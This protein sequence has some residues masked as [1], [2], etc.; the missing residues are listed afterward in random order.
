MCTFSGETS[1]PVSVHT[2]FLVG[3]IQTISDSLPYPDTHTRT[4]TSYN[5]YTVHKGR[6]AK[7]LPT[8]TSD[9]IRFT[10]KNTRERIMKVTVLKGS[11]INQSFV[12]KDELIKKFIRLNGLPENATRTG[13]RTRIQ[14]INAQKT[15]STLIISIGFRFFTRKIVSNE[16]NFRS[17]VQNVILIGIIKRG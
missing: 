3:R 11:V 1:L 13:T 4:Q 17:S 5:F 7:D 15:T 8:T 16:T 12:Y 9:R 2:F 14:A 10:R 6:C